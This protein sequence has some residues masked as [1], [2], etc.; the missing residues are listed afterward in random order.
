VLGG[1]SDAGN[2]KAAEFDSALMLRGGEQ[3]GGERR[4]RES[5]KHALILRGL[6]GVIDDDDLNRSFAGIELEAKLFL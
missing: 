2:G 3:A 4:D 1:D 6:F 5:A